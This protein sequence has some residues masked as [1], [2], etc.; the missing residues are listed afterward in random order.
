MTA[1]ERAGIASGGVGLVVFLGL[2][3]AWILPIWFILP[4]GL[5]VAALGGL[6]V[7]RAYEVLLPHLP[8]RQWHAAMVALGLG[9]VV[10]PA[11]ILAELRSPMFDLGAPGGAMLL[12]SPPEAAALFI[13]ELLLTASAVGALLGWVVARTRRAATVSA[14]AGLAF[15]IGLGHNI[16]FGGGTPAVPLEIAIMGIV[17]ASA[18]VTLVEGYAWLLR[19]DRRAGIGTLDRA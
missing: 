4:A 15:A 9:I 16:P 2:H 6:A 3:H 14:V 12:V 11:V 1:A 19:R 7:G 8:S 13:G 17:T 10:A 18:A 5:P